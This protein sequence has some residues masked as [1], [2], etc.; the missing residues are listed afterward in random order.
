[1]NLYCFLN[2]AW[3][4]EIMV[5]LKSQGKYSELVSESGLQPNIVLNSLLMQHLVLLELTV[6]WESRIED[7]HVFKLVKQENLV[8]KFLQE[9]GIDTLPELELEVGARGLV[10]I[11]VHDT[12]K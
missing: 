8:A 12:L 4:W 9:D 1:M 10:P 6:P 5:D 2:G 11:S 3:D 7:Q